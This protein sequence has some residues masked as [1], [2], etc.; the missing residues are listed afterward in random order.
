MLSIST[1]PFKSGLPVHVNGMFTLSSNRRDLWLDAQGMEGVGK[2]RALWNQRLL[3]DVVAPTYVWTL[4]IMKDKLGFTKEFLDLI[5]CETLREPWNL[6]ADRTLSLLKNERILQ[7][8][9][10]KKWVCRI[11]LQFILEH[12]HTH[13]INTHRI[14]DNE[15]RTRTRSSMRRERPNHTELVSGFLD[16]KTTSFRDASLGR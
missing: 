16:N 7:T 5:P 10:S 14:R 13:P 12:T 8:E 9:F 11:Y 15:R 4:R 3:S 6:V 2:T 1:L